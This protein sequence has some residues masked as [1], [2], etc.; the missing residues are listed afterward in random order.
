[1]CVEQLQRGGKIVGE[2]PAL[3]KSTTRTDMMTMLN[4]S[5]TGVAG[6]CCERR[7]SAQEVKGTFQKG[8]NA[9]GEGLVPTR[10][11]RR[12]GTQGPDVR[13]ETQTGRDRG[14]Y[15]PNTGE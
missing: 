1:L 12:G 14:S 13:Q 15:C 11:H 2:E 8:P 10:T 7:R 9:G 3:K 4:T 5:T 6:V